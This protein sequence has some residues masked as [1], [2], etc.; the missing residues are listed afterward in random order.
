MVNCRPDMF[1]NVAE[2][3][4]YINSMRKVGDIVTGNSRRRLLGVLY[5]SCFYGSSRE[6]M[7]AASL[8]QKDMDIVVKA[9][10]QLSIVYRRFL[11]NEHGCKLAAGKLVSHWY[12]LSLLKKNAASM[13]NTFKRLGDMTGL[14]EPPKPKIFKTYRDLEWT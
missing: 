3:A 12:Y 10:E 1:N 14:L 13:V 7:E 8:S 11:K 5:A 2:Y 4:Q 6:D 9:S